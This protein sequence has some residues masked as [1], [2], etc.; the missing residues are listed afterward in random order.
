MDKRNTKFP[1]FWLVQMRGN[2]MLCRTEEEVGE[3]PF[4][5][6][7]KKKTNSFA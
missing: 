4:G 5:R 7:T 3:T 2:K 6:Q 1:I